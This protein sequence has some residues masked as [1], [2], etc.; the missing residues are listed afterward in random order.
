MT[1]GEALEAWARQ[2]LSN[3][4]SRHPHGKGANP[5]LKI[6]DSSFTYHQGRP[7]SWGNGTA[8]ELSGFAGSHTTEAIEVLPQC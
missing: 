8:P 6:D 5:K 1:N 7:S 2:W 3:V 4:V